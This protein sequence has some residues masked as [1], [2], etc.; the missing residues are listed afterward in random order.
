MKLITEVTEE[1]KYIS[2]EGAEGKKNLYI[3]GI[4]L[5][6]NIKN[7]NGRMYNTETLEK[8]VNRYRTEN[9]DKGRAY[10]ELGHPSGPSINL[11]RVCMMIK[12]LHREGDNFIGKAKIMDTPYGNI[13]KNLMSEGATLGV[14]SRGMGSL[15]EVNGVN[16]VQDDFYLATAADIVADPSAPDAYVNGVMEGVEWV[17]N[18]GILKAQTVE[19]HKNII[20]ETPKADLAEAKMRVFQHFLSKL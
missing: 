18:N 12:S 1:L 16:V 9:I 10:G 11:E 13:V 2:E 8:E 3:E 19:Q 17:W 6:G 20:K 5:Q 15:K 14:S 7:R 4:F